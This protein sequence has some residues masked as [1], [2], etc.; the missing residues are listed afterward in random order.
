MIIVLL[1]S[2]FLFFVLTSGRP[3]RVTTFFV[4]SKP[5]CSHFA[6]QIVIPEFSAPLQKRCLWQSKGF[7][8]Q[9]E[10]AKI[11]YCCSQPFYSSFF[12]QQRCLFRTGASESKFKFA[13]QKKKCKCLLTLFGVTKR[14]IANVSL[15]TILKG[16]SSNSAKSG[17]HNRS[18]RVILLVLLE[19][20]ALIRPLMINKILCQ[21]EL[22]YWLSY[23]G[24]QNTLSDYHIKVMG[25]FFVIFYVSIDIIFNTGNL[26]RKIL[27]THTN[28][29]SPGKM[30][31]YHGN[32]VPVTTPSVC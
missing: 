31:I 12:L 7:P 23:R 15:K 10:T 14:M 1:K 19:V 8:L 4:F 3:L 5:L 18:Q 26:P 2:A 25:T 22:C 27:V 20:K 13:L 9:R 17:H 28:T 21:L 30:F 6:A 11:C 24:Q 16:S 32:S 29:I